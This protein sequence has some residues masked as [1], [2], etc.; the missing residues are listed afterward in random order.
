MLQA[1]RRHCPTAS[2]L[3]LFARLHVVKLCPATHVNKKTCMQQN[4]L[5]CPN[6][7][8]RCSSDHRNF[9]CHKALR[10]MGLLRGVIDSV[11]ARLAFFPPSPPS[12]EVPELFALMHVVTST[13]CS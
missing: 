9:H 3:S 5:R 2:N 4:I 7:A 13:S 10:P 6:V 12:Y 8:L 1:D 11:S